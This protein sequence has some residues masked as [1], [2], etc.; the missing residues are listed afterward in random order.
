MA[1]DNKSFIEGNDWQ[2]CC[3]KKRAQ[4]GEKA[5]F[6]GCTAFGVITNGRARPITIY[7]R[8]D[9]DP[10][11]DFEKTVS[12]TDVDAMLADGWVVD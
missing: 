5:S 9:D 3:V 12:Y 1:Y 8:A 11:K 10:R 7:L 6:M 4:A 2:T